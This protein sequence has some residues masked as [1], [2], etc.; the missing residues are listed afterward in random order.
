MI[1]PIYSFVMWMITADLQT[2]SIANKYPTMQECQEA[3]KNVW[4]FLEHQ[5]KD[6]PHKIIN[7]NSTPCDDFSM[8][9]PDKEEKKPEPEKRPEGS[10]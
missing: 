6:D 3:Y 4:D 10:I 1:V 9:V 7:A 8:N 2:Y 5:D